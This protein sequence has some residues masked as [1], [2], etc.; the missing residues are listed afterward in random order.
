MTNDRIDELRAA[1]TPYVDFEPVDELLDI[2]EAL[3]GGLA[4]LRDAI[5]ACNRNPIPNSQRMRWR[6]MCDA[7]L[8]KLEVKP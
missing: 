6:D 1:I 5:H 2:A 7:L 3:R 8:A 4:D